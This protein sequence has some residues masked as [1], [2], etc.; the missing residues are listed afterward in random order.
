MCV[1][2]HVSGTVS[3]RVRENAFFF[4]NK[5]ILRN[6]CNLPKV[7]SSRVPEHFGILVKLMWSR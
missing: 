6:Q 5:L 7:A 2:V 1:F 3:E 4:M